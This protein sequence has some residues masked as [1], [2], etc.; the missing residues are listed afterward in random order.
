[1]IFKNAL[2]IS[3]AA[4]VLMVSE[5]SCKKQN[6]VPE[7]E[8]FT[9]AVTDREI[10]TWVQDSL[11]RYYYWTA[12][13]S[14]PQNLNQAPLNY[15]NAIKYSADRFSLLYNPDL[16]ETIPAYARAKFGFDFAFIGLPNSDKIV[17]VIKMVEPDS[18]AG[19]LG[20]KR[21]DY[22]TKVNGIEINSSNISALKDQIIKS[23][24]FKII[25]ASISSDL[26]VL[27]KSE[28]QINTGKVYEEN[29]V[30]KIFTL[31]NQKVGYLYFNNFTVQNKSLFVDVFADYKSKNISD[32][33]IDLRYN[34]GG[35]VSC[36]AAICAMIVPN[37][38][39]DLP[40]IKYQGNKNGGSR[41]ETFLQSALF[42]GGP[43][44]STY[45]Q[46]NIG[47]NK[48]Y[49]L[50]SSSTASAA[51]II[52]NNLKPYINVLQIG[53][54]TRGKDEASFTI[55]DERNPKRINYLMLP[56]VYKV[57]NSL[58]VGAYSNGLMPTF[59]VSE[60]TDFPLKPLG[61]ESELYIKTSLQLITG[62]AAS[63]ALK[64]NKN[65]MME[66]NTINKVFYDSGIEAANASIAI[67]HH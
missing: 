47:L 23:A 55:K 41:V 20:L 5:T 33:I 38:K 13:M 43:A 39:P 29:Y 32:L 52:I 14:I 10:N 4:F 8:I 65:K 56:I 53:E 46:N 30:S 21:G 67:T 66:S 45:A 6:A 7:K 48:V 34:A 61:D 22:F 12:E 16:P 19:R 15:F 25:L 49:V 2:S 1:M 58:G 40:F 50:T 42:S 51:E 35:D 54:K 28:I 31:P 26:S 24:S 17:G 9:G 57:F 44:F 59:N 63:V 36:A 3:I 37:I 27:E 62:N 18:P 64:V 60:F 11:K